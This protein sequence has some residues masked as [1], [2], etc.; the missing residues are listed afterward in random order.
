LNAEAVQAAY[1]PRTCHALGPELA[2]RETLDDLPRGFV[3]HDEAPSIETHDVLATDGPRQ[4]D[5]RLE[6]R[7][8]LRRK[9]GHDGHIVSEC[10][11]LIRWPHNDHLRVRRAY[12]SITVG[13]EHGE[14]VITWRQV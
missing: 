6:I 2:L 13:R 14:D 8:H 12:V 3:V 7:P 1:S 10:R 4:I 11:R 5:I 9:G